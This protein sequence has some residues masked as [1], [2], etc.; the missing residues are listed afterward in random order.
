MSLEN[1]GWT[2]CV[3]QPRNRRRYQDAP[4]HLEELQTA[5]VGDS[6]CMQDVLVPAEV[7][8]HQGV[9]CRD[10]PRG[11][12]PT[13]FLEFI[14]VESLDISPVRIPRHAQKVLP[15]KRRKASVSDDVAET[16]SAS[17]ME[18]K[19]YSPSLNLERR[20]TAESDSGDATPR[21]H[22]LDRR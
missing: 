1:N 9:V 8:D 21:S 6:L 15:P 20:S 7:F 5:A 2:R 10:I 4:T 13:I 18:A 22:R 16:R 19:V 14:P 12:G 3:L 17:S 11:C